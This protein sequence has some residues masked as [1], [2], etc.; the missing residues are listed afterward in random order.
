MKFVQLVVGIIVLGVLTLGIWQQIA[1]RAGNKLVDEANAASQAANKS[2]EDAAKIYK[3]LITDE[4]INALP[5]NRNTIKPKVDQ[6]ASL[7]EKST[8]QFREAASKLDEAS[9]KVTTDVLV[10]YWKTRADAIRK[11][12]DQ[13][14][15][16][17]KIVLLLADESVVDMATF[18]E[19]ANPLVEQANKHN[20]AAEEAE[21]KATKIQT[22]NKDKIQQN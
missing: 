2:T 22:D 7:F 19:K 20:A 18:N 15:T 3:E 14:E 10:E 11:R 5:G 6:A 16:L 9:G 4:V 1:N 17:R 8:S 13:K 21:A 12:A